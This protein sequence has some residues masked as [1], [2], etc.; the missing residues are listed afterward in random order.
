MTHT[1]YLY[2]TFLLQI[3]VISAVIPRLINSRVNNMLKAHPPAQYPKL[4]PMPQPKMQQNLKQFMA[5]NA[6]VL[7]LG[8]AIL[9]HAYWTGQQELLAWDTQ[10]ILNIYFFLQLLPFVLLGSKGMKYQQMMRQID[11]SSRRTASLQPRQLTNYV[12]A[13]FL[14]LVGI[15]ALV[16][17]LTVIYIQQNPFPGFVGYWN[18]LFII[19]LNAFFFTMIHFQIRR[20]K[21]D[22]HQTSHDRSAQIRLITHVLVIG[23]IAANLF[24]ATNMWLSLWQLHELKDVVQSGYFTL[25]ALLLSQI[26]TFQPEDYS[27]YQNELS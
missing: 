14:L 8:L 13:T 1:S 22:P 17:V 9:V 24:L 7:L 21:S 3:G 20:K 6:L 16:L 11:N 15:S 18:L 12:S 27:V 10:S 19:L 25:T 4:Y 23:C 26:S 2:L 5:F